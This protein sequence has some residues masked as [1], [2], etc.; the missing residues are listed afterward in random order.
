MFLNTSPVCSN[1]TCGGGDEYIYISFFIVIL[2][3]QYI[4]DKLAISF[5][6]CFQI[7]HEMN[8]RYKKD[9]R[10]QFHE[11]YNFNCKSCSEIC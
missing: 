11:N 2:Y 4:E 7:M 3:K 8:L 6:L 1:C 5:F 9:F 10:A